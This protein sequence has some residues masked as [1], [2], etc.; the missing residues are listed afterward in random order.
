MARALAWW[1]RLRASQYATDALNRVMC[2]APYQPG[3]MVV[4]FAIDFITFY[5]ILDDQVAI[6]LIHLLSIS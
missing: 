5:N 6:I 4:V 1:R 2:L 3:D